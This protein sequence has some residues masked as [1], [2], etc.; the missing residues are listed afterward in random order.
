MSDKV[1]Q[2]TNYRHEFKIFAGYDKRDPN[3]SKN[4]GIH[5]VEMKWFVIGDKGAVQFVLSTSWYPS[6]V[7]RE[8][9]FDRGKMYRKLGALIG[10]YAKLSPD[11]EAL[12]KDDN[13]HA[14]LLNLYGKG[15]YDDLSQDDL[16]DWERRL[17]SRIEKAK[18][19]P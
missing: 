10:D 18:V 11:G 6:N 8:R 16:L 17:R 2:A 15:S 5:G 1:T 3:P 9:G 12:K 19:A 13:R 7:R 4:Y 14:A